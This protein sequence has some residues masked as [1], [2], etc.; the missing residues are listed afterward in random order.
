MLKS[1]VFSYGF[2]R[3]L[4]RKGT[5]EGQIIQT[6][7]M[8]YH[9][10]IIMIFKCNKDEKFYGVRYTDKLQKSHY[11][12]ECQEIRLVTKTEK[13]WEWVEEE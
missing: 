1:K 10:E 11:N 7:V 4:T 13:Q 12:Y 6:Q 3:R 5:K 8:G 9:K 2:L